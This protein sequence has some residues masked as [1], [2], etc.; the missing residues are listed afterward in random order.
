MLD[1]QVEYNNYAQ[2]HMREEFKELHAVSV[3]WGNE[4]RQLCAPPR[5]KSISGKIAD[6]IPPGG[7]QAGAPTPD[8]PHDVEVMNLC[9]SKLRAIERMVFEAEYAWCFG[10]DIKSKLQWLRRERKIGM[11]KS[12][13]NH[14]LMICRERVSVAFEILF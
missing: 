9:V 5:P 3:K 11:S 7:S 13:Y 4:K 8:A 14:K 2:R 6:Q 10:W 1:I 12:Q